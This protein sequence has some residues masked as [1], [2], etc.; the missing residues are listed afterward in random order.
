MMAVISK[1]LEVVEDWIEPL[2]QQSRYGTK[3]P[4]GD[5]Y[6]V[7]FYESGQLHT[8]REVAPIWERKTDFSGDAGK[9]LIL[10]TRKASKGSINLNNVHPFTATTDDDSFVFCHNGTIFDIDKLNPSKTTDYEDTS[11]SRIFFELFL[12]KYEFSGDFV[13]AVRSTV[14][15]IAATCSSITSMNSFFSNGKQLI[16]VRYCLDEEDYYTLGYTKLRD[17]DDGYVITTQQYDDKTSWQ[18][19]ENKTI[20]VFQSD[21]FQ[22]FNISDH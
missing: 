12:N 11:D 20:T 10:H 2:V 7:A 22:Q 18:W 15:D 17:S 19:L 21:G 8:R 14:S 4:H 16:A 3:H 5:G 1:R 9:I 13:E 6:G